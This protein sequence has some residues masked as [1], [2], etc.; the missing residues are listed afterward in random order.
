MNI[1]INALSARRGGGQTY[2]CNLLQHIDC[3]SNDAIIV[4]A[5]DSLVL[6]NHPAIR[7]VEVDWPTANPLLRTVWE[8]CFLPKFIEKVQAD[9]LFCPGGLINCCVPTNCR[10]VTMSQNMIP[11]TPSIR[12]QYPIGWQR[13]RNWL[14][15]RGMLRSIKQA[16]LVIFISEYARGV[17][18][19]YIGKTIQNAVVVPHGISHQFRIV[20]EHEPLR[21]YWLPD[22]E[23]LLYVSIF[24]PYKNH[25]EVVRGF[26]QLKSLRSTHEKLVLAG[27]ND[28]PAGIAVREEISRLGLQDEVILVGNIDYNDLPALYYHAKINIFA[29]TCENCPNIL[30]EA[31][32]ASR[33]LLVSNIQPMPEFGGEA[34]LY[35]DPFSPEDF[36]SKVL[37]IIDNPDE[38]NHLGQLAAKQAINFNWEET[39]RATWL[40]IRAVAPGI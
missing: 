30:L 37:S 39:A 2:L 16:D 13:L 40:T 3:C 32:G 11:F 7:R 19:T 34:V 20:S 15:E 23:Y 36:A 18:E 10:T 31:L 35:F 24:E 21:P 6:P 26:H 5:P 22:G 28:M 4:I 17:I 27:K 12:Q 29:S 14:L 33:P 38:L 9:V 8:K 25:I 1:V